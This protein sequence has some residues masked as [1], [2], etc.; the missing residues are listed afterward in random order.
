[1]STREVCNATTIEQILT[2]SMDINK[3]GTA[4]DISI[5]IPDSVH[6]ITKETN[7]T[8]SYPPSKC[9]TVVFVALSSR[10]Q[11][12]KQNI[13]LSS[14]SSDFQNLENL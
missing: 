14:A 8:S 12:P 5:L 1:M 7:G 10:N 13:G 9:T 3:K 11:Q 2:R 4:P 6:H